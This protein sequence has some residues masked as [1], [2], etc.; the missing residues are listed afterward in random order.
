MGH[1]GRRWTRHAD[2]WRRH[3]TR[4][5]WSGLRPDTLLDNS[6]RSADADDGSPRFPCRT[7]APSRR[8]R[9]GRR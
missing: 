6:R 2:A 1:F 8:V 5:A 3:V 9:V 7:L 4:N